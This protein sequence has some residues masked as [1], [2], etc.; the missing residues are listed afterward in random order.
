MSVQPPAPLEELGSLSAVPIGLM[1][2][3]AA[4]RA[5]LPV[6][7][8]IVFPPQLWRELN[9]AGVNL[10][11][12]NAILHQWYDAFTTLKSEWVR[13]GVLINAS[14]RWTAHVMGENALFQ[15][16]S[17][18]HSK[19]RT[20]EP[21][22]VVVQ[23]SP[24]ASA[25]GYIDTRHG[26]APG[27]ARIACWPGEPNQIVDAEN[28]TTA[29]VRISDKTVVGES[30]TTARYQAGSTKDGQM[31]LKPI[32][33]LFGLPQKT[34]LALLEDIM[35]FKRT[36]PDHLN[37]H[38]LIVDKKP[39]ITDISPDYGDNIDAF[40]N[41]PKLRTQVLLATG[42][43][44]E[45]E[46][47]GQHQADGVGILRSDYLWSQLDQHPLWLFTKRPKELRKHITSYLDKTRSTHP[48][49]RVI[50]RLLNF[51]SDELRRLQHGK[52]FEEK[53]T[54]PYLGRRGA[55]WYLSHPEFLAFELETIADWIDTR[56]A[57][58]GVL[59]PFV[60]DH[61][62]WLRMIAQL[63]KLECWENPLFELWLQ[64]TTPANVAQIQ[65]YLH[66]RLRGIILHVKTISALAHGIDPDIDALTIEYRPDTTWLRDT[67]VQL[68]NQTQ[69]TSQRLLKY[70]F[71]EDPD[72]GL[73][74]LAVQTQ[75]DGVVAAPQALAVVRAQLAQFEASQ[76]V[77]EHIWQ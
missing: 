46:L 54:N 53:E 52:E 39:I 14:I 37:L 4:K 13:V 44:G 77:A 17:M 74:E 50:Y 10:Y 65:S 36:T 27:V 63:E 28:P 60:R 26:S 31:Q 47:S 48:N 35:K 19:S 20:G 18:L 73:L 59:V 33:P 38:Y 67:L 25:Y 64:L 29:L 3:S 66:P 49:Q 15:E 43:I 42:S 32:D 71:A 12:N 76:S 16:L 55:H 57:P 5:N 34:L 40:T 61:K 7:K 56:H 75:Y 69:H 72:P 70:V 2:L 68:Q 22:W 45:L 41:L 21:L 1:L 6:A 30:Q 51:N 24:A 9:I 58:T 11:T 23:A 8:T 62:E